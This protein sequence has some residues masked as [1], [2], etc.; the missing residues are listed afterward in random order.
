MP[1]VISI[2]PSRPS[3]YEITKSTSLIPGQNRAFLLIQ[4]IQLRDIHACDIDELLHRHPSCGHCERQSCINSRTSVQDA[5][6]PSLR[7]SALKRTL[8]AAPCVLIPEGTVEVPMARP[9]QMASWWAE[10]SCEGGLQTHS[11]P[12]KPGLAR[13]GAH[14][15]E[16]LWASF[17]VDGQAVGLGGMA[18][19][20][21]RGLKGEFG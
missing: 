3:G 11:A 15:E 16:A 20:G 12:S 1:L 6:E 4:A 18:V 7:N 5:A 10:D 17:C 19:G 21:G 14:N 8:L 9:I 2:S 13:V